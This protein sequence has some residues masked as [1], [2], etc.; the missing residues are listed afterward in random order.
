MCASLWR[1][2]RLRPNVTC[3]LQALHILH[4]ALDKLALVGA[5]RVDPQ[6]R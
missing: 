6:V 2:V 3:L 4:A 5:T 1:M